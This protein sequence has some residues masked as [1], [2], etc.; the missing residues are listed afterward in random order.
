MITPEDAPYM[1]LNRTLIDQSITLASLSIEKEDLSKTMDDE[2][3]DDAFGL[4]L[5]AIATLMHSLPSKFLL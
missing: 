5:A 2:A 3:A 4:Y 1:K